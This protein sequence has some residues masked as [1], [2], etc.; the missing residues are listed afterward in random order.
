MEPDEHAVG[1]KPEGVSDHV[2]AGRN[3]KH[4][5][6]RDGL[7]NESRLIG[8]SIAFGTEG[9]QIDPGSDRRQAPDRVR[10]GWRQGF[11]RRGMVAGLDISGCAQ[12]RE[13]KSM[14][15]DFHLVYLPGSGKL[16]AALA[17]ARKDRHL[18]A[19]DALEIDLGHPAILIADQDC[20]A[21][22]VLKARV[23]YPKLVGI[24]RVDRDGGGNIP[25]LIVDQRQSGFILADRRL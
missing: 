3:V 6:L 15:K 18:A 8:R 2:A 20:R 13:S 9:S 16:A 25:E 12:R 11:E 22:D 5:M 17:K 7:L 14:R 19:D 10:R 23:F 1:A 24:M 21:A 4:T